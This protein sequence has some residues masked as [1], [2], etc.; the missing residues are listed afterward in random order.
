MG[1]TTGYVEARTKDTTPA[2][3]P[4]FNN[5]IDPGLNGPFF[6]PAGAFSSTSEVPFIGVYTAFTKGNL[7]LDGQAR[8]DLIE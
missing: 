5:V 7:A 1:V 8:W 2:G 3:G 6:T 4:Y